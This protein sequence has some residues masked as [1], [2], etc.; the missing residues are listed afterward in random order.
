MNLSLLASSVWLLVQGLLVIASAPLLLGWIRKLRCYL[1]SRAAPSIFQPY[2]SLYKL[3]CKQPVVASNAS[4]LFRFAPLV[5]MACLATI[6]QAV[7]LFFYQ[8]L[9]S[10]YVDVIVVV[11][12]FAMARVWMTL[13][14]MDVGTAFGSLGARRELFV[15]CLAEPVLLLVLLNMGLITHGFTLGNIS[16]V[17]TQQMQ[18]YPG[19]V[20]SLCAFVFVLLAE[21][22]RIPFDNPST[23]LELTMVHEAMVLEYSGR[24]L[25]LIE[26]GSA[27]KLMLFFLLFINLFCPSGLAVSWSLPALLLGGITTVVKLFLLV[28]LMAIAEACQAKVRLFI[29]PEYLTIALLLA[30]LGLLLTQLT[31]VHL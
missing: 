7:P 17:L 18:L 3:L 28:S 2:F 26:W 24:Y 23:H 13:A 12:L 19:I 20:F 1:Q 9:L 5:Y 6:A 25:A 11:G 16:Y 31:G 27:L 8:G 15:A 10:S 21:N 29:V 30:L 4:W 22:G 14:A